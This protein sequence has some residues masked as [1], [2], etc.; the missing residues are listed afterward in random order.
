MKLT[1]QE[2]RAS[3]VP[4]PPLLR[5]F[6]SQAGVLFGAGDAEIKKTKTKTKPSPCP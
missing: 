5:A 4:T 2:R 3:G 1:M 6:E